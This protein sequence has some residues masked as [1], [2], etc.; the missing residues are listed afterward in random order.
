MKNN[1]VIAIILARGGSKGIPRKNVLDFAGH[2]LLAWTVIQ[3]KLSS[4]VDEVYLSSDSD[5]ILEIGERYGANTIKRPDSIAG[6]SAKSEE[7]IIHALSI[8]GSSQEII[9]M[10][11]PTAPLRKANDIDN[12]IKMF[13]NKNWDSCFSGA[14]LQDFLLWKKDENGNLKSLNY[15]YRKQGPRQEREP[16]YVE[17]GAIYMFKPEIMINEKNRFGGKI[18]LFPNNFWQ[19]FEIDD[20]E[21]WEFVELIF[22]EYLLTHDYSNFMEDYLSSKR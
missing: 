15:D 22:R 5:E 8:L 12:C 20:I 6:D 11:E 7:A 4:E 2:P 9:I 19:S 13:R 3:A 1:K 21:D 16:D 14:L 10:L 17:N 18:G